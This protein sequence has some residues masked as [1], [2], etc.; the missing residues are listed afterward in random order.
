MS[1]APE[2]DG[3]RA[4]PYVGLRAFRPDEHGLFFGRTS[5]SVNIA[6]MW[7]A[8]K[9]TMLYGASGVGKTSLLQAGV[10][11][12]LD[13]NRFEVW[14][15]GRLQ[16]GP[17]PAVS[18]T[19]ASNPY[20]L[21]L[22]SSW[23][24]REPIASLTELGILGLL[25]KRREH[26]DLYGD[27]IPTL[28]AIDQAEELFNGPP[29]WRSFVRP[30]ILELADALREYR[31]LRLLLCFREDHLAAVLP[32]EQ[33]LADQSRTRSRL[34]PFDEHAALE[35]IQGPLAGT[36]RSFERGAAEELVADLRTIKVTNALGEESTLTVDSIEP[37]QIQVVCSALWDSLPEDASVITSSHVREH[38]DVDKFLANFCSRALTAVAREHGVGAARIRAWLQ[39]TFITELGTRGTAYVGIGQTAGMPNA[40]VRALEDLHILKAELRLGTRWYELQHDRLIEP[41]RQGDPKEHLEAARL[42]RDEDDWDLAE[43]HAIR[44][45]RVFGAEDLRVR[46]EAEGL[47]GEVAQARGQIEDALGHYHTGARLLEVVQDAAAVGEQ[48]AAAGRLSLACGRYS[49]AVTDLRAAIARNPGDLEVQTDLAEA[50]WHTGQPRAA[51]AVL[52]VVLTVDGNMTAAL[53]ARGEILADLDDKEAA[54]RDLDRV[55][56]HQQPA[57][58]AARALA[59]AQLGRF[60][61]AEQEAAD[62]LANGQDN[63]PVL[64]RAARV[65]ALGGDRVEAMRLAAGA[66]AASSPALP[67]HMRELAQRLLGPGQ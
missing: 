29:Q 55:R 61:A 60:E 66:L 38:V 34:L 1:V 28:V 11:P 40:V 49:A 8:N 27:P 23:A 12:A 20:T 7:R 5:E 31:G 57:T 52:T 15:I 46:A 19:Q 22:L 44:A 58:Q 62:A 47:L 59:L 63:G 16:P 25:R 32:Y 48:L 10:I 41:I 36:G 65:C 18:A 26:T 21:A 33:L 43:R 39:H 67:P 53:R 4:Q 51:A 30:F 35:A 42:A 9:L 24:P 3:P 13:R 56:R 14:P 64:L 37:V 17:A 6:R 54:L 45:I 2:T 50:M